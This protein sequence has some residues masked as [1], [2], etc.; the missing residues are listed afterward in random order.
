MRPFDF[1]ASYAYKQVPPLKGADQ[2]DEWTDIELG[3]DN[4]GG[5]SLEAENKVLL[6]TVT[7]S[8]TESGSQRSSR[9]SSHSNSQNNS[10]S[11]TPDSQSSRTHAEC[12]R[13]IDTRLALLTLDATLRRVAALRKEAIDTTRREVAR[14]GSTATLVN[15]IQLQNRVIEKQNAQQIVDK[16]LHDHLKLQLAN[17]DCPQERGGGALKHGYGALDAKALNALEAEAAEKAVRGITNVAGRGR[18]HGRGIG[19]G[20]GQVRGG[21]GGAKA[22]AP[23]PFPI[24]L[25]SKSGGSNTGDDENLTNSGPR[26]PSKHSQLSGSSNNDIDNDNHHGSGS[27]DLSQDDPPRSHPITTSLA[28]LRAAEAS[29]SEGNGSCP[30]CN[31]RAPP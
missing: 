7:T 25:S 5:S 31:I 2:E 11:S 27:D 28:D 14:D 30:R 12:L 23:R 21:R 17:R 18:G 6:D 29:T 16:Q 1:A 26:T 15:I 4:R 22:R 9:S 13:G 8:A 10:R 20:R 24:E 3:D 19:R